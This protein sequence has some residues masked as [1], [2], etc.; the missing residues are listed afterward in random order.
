MTL[1][2]TLCSI[3]YLAQA[4]TLAESLAATNPD[5]RFV[6]G[7]VD[8]LD[9]VTFDED[10]QAPFELIEV[11][12]LEIPNF[13]WMVA[14]YDITELNTAVKPYFIEKFFR[15]NTEVERVIYFD[16]DIIVFQPLTHLLGQL[17]Q[18]PIVVT[19]HL[20]VPHRDNLSTN[21]NDHLNTGTFNLGFIALRRH[22]ETDRFVTWWME[23]LAYECFNDVCNG[24]FTDQ[25]WINLVPI[26]FQNVGIEKHPGY[27]VAYW[28][29]H[30]RR[31]SQRQ[32]VFFVNDTHMLQFFHFSGYGLNRL[33]EVSKYQNRHHFANRADIVPLFA[34]Y[35]ERLTAHHNAYY[36][37]FPCAYV[38]PPVVRRWKRVRKALRTPLLKL[39]D[40]IEN[41]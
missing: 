8:R 7:L 20:T 41:Q 18:H 38:K 22:P 29:L 32:G 19:P 1:A 27:N 40:W 36:A 34:H 11:H 28:N 35:A 31:M 15:E 39:A 26:Y 3:N 2:F 17:E 25:K 5:F 37:N 21:E 16:P 30:E 4:R 12:R 23:K 9:A 13:A 10:K 14:H 6:V 33:D 24:L